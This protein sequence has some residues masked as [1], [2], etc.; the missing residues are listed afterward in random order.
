MTGRQCWPFR[1]AGQRITLKR[2]LGI[3]EFE[4][5]FEHFE[6]FS[7]EFQRGDRPSWELAA[8]YI[9]EAFES[10]Y[11]RFEWMHLTAA[12]EPLP[13]DIRLHRMQVGWARSDSDCSAST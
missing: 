8:A 5:F 11:K 13:C 12:G 1:R 6:R 10:G 4:Q 7:P 9:G 3:D 2:I